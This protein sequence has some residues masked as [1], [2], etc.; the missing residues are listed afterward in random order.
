MFIALRIQTI[1]SRTVL[2][3]LSKAWSRHGFSRR[4]EA[5]YNKESK[6]QRQRQQTI[7]LMSRT[8]AVHVR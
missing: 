4:D 7:G 1:K 6:P 2:T 8:M 3:R 5:M